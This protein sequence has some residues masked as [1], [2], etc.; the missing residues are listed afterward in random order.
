MIKNRK[1]VEIILHINE[2]LKIEQ[3]NHLES[4]LGNDEGITDAR[5]NLKRKHL[6]L[7]DYIPGVVTAREV[8]SYVHNHGY[9]AELVGGL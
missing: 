6:M 8:L 5:M 4:L 9:H 7:V 1:P 2:N 3:I